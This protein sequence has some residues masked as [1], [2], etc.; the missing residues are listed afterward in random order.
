MPAYSLQPA[1][2]SSLPTLAE[3]FTRA[4]AA[5]FVPVDMTVPALAEF[6]RREGVDLG[7]SRVLFTDATPSGLAL[8]ARRGW[9]TRL[10]AMGIFESIRGRG[11]GTWLA[12]Q[13]IE[14]ARQRGDH[15]MVLEVIEQN[16]PGVRL[17]ERL[18]FTSARRLVGFAPGSP[19][20]SPNPDLVGIDPREVGTQAG[21]HGLPDLPWQ[22]SAETLAMLTLPCRAY[23]LGPARAVI[24]D[25]AANPVQFRAVIV[26]PDARHQGHGTRLLR[27]I[28]AHHPGRV[29]SVP[30]IWPEEISPVFDRLGLARG[31]LSQWQMRL[32][33]V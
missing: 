8:V 21:R 2:D 1:L 30:P 9:T 14:D 28:V 15:A 5:Y 16:L 22:M 13:M 20:P 12:G 18:G 17:Y 29:W 24:S 3:V 27:A 6:L 25:P 31:P 11:A 4:F 23:R 10:A 33:L 7:A 32:S 19:E 26:E